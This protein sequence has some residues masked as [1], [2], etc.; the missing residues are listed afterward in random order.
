MKNL[1]AKSANGVEG[2]ILH[3][4]EGVYIFRVYGKKHE[5]VDYTILHCDLN[6]VINDSDAYFYTD[7]ER[8]ILDQSPRTLG[9]K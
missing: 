9:L 4:G 7:G 2:C 6:V 1:L 3:V 8:N 5:F